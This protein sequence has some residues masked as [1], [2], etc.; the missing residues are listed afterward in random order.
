[1]LPPVADKL[2]AGV[3]EDRSLQLTGVHVLVV[4]GRQAR[5]PARVLPVLLGGE[6]GHVPA[7]RACLLHHV[8]QDVVAAV[9]AHHGERAEPRLGD[10]VVDIADDAGQRV[11][12]QAD[13][14]TPGAVLV[15]AGDRHRRQREDRVRQ[16][17]L[18]RDRLGYD[19]VGDQREVTTMLLETPDGKHRMDGVPCL[20]LRRRTGWQ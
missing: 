2:R 17:H 7:R 1:M 19:R 10:G 11:G 12:R 6:Q 14:R 5:R 13:R 8:R 16:L 18:A 20:R 4:G 3:Q 15:R 9:P